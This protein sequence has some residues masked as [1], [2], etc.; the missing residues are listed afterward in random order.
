MS[1]LVLVGAS[2]P[3]ALGAVLHGRRRSFDIVVGAPSS[4]DGLRGIIVGPDAS[5]EVIGELVGLALEQEIPALVFGPLVAA[6][7]GG[8]TTPIGG[9]VLRRAVITEEGAEDGVTAATMPGAPVVVVDELVGDMGAASVLLRD[10]EGGVLL[11]RR[12]PIHATSWRLDA[13]V[14][15]VPDVAA[16]A[17]LIVPH[18]AALLGRWIDVAVGRTD[19]ERP[20]GR[21]GPQPVA[22]PG[23]SLHPA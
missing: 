17:A 23:L 2:F 11:V 3:P 21:R 13:E 6:V 8:A 7:V 12:G 15:D 10:E 9:P 5:P 1:R 20:W 16:H 19:E 18:A 14:T 22:A 4:P